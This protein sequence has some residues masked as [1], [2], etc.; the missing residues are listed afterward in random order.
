M[1]IRCGMSLYIPLLVCI[2]TRIYLCLYIYVSLYVYLSLSRSLNWSC[3][4]PPWTLSPNSIITRVL[5]CQPHAIHSANPRYSKGLRTIS[6]RAWI[7][8]WPAS[9]ASPWAE[10]EDAQGIN[11]W[12]TRM[13][14]EDCQTN[15]HIYKNGRHH[16]MYVRAEAVSI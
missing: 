3:A 2:N 8:A 9:I 15:M 11:T 6:A 13:Y 14:K 10:S 4:E 12:E 1:C 16:C 5:W 7:A